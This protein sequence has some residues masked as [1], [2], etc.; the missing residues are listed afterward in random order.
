MNLKKFLALAVGPVGGAIL[1]FVSLPILAWTFLPDD[2]GRLSLLQVAVGFS[3]SILSLG[4]DQAFVR[5]F[6]DGKNKASLLKT[7]FLPGFSL[8]AILILALL[9]AN[10]NLSQYLFDE[11][12]KIFNIIICICLCCNFILVFSQLVL[13]M[14]EK[15]LLYSLST[16]SNRVVFMVLIL[17]LFIGGRNSDFTTLLLVNIISVLVSLL[18]S[19]Y[20]S[21]RE[22]WATIFAP[23]LTED[24]GALLRFSF[25]LIAGGIAF[26]GL[27][28]T[29]RI[30][31]RLWGDFTQLGYFSV[32]ASVAA[33]AN[34]VQSIF[35]VMWTPFVYKWHADGIDYDR[36][37]EIV[38]LV[39]FVIASTFALVGMF[40]WCVLY[41]LPSKY[42]IVAS[43]IP[44]CM[45]GALLYTLSE[46][47]VVG[48]HLSKRTSFA[49]IAPVLAFFLNVA[50]NFLLVPVCGAAGA[51][52]ATI[53]SFFIFLL[54]RTEF[55]VVF[56]RSF[57]RRKMYFISLFCTIYSCLQAV[58]MNFFGGFFYV[59][60]TL[61]FVLLIFLYR[62]TIRKL[63]HQYFSVHF[64]LF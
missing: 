37:D 47:T 25:P 62:G 42:E 22:W 59:G 51:A 15:A 20:F 21:R 39:L 57:R 8:T 9:M 24:F 14:H 2:I 64:K 34:I 26:W 33:V 13:R 17:A 5:E 29:D 53:A 58:Y 32:A 48:L 50:I 41:I 52:V 18:V 45:G 61:F 16:L 4:L 36:L 7:T 43:L 30:S 28:S 56:W 1:G 63:V 40:S 10:V 6:F 55:S 38:D 35:S 31:I 44:A 54:L 46:T 19:L 12:S 49:M 27:T 23:F 60:W 11:Q 3:F